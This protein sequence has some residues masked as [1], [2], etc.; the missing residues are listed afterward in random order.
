M[1]SRN[2]DPAIFTPRPRIA[3]DSARRSGLR[4]DRPEPSPA[5]KLLM[6]LFLGGVAAFALYGF[7]EFCILALQVFGVMTLP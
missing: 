4:A 1:D 2:I 5:R 6:V 3:T 7:I